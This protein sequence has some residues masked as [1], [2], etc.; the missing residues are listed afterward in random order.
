MASTLPVSVAPILLVDL[1]PRIL[2]SIL[3]HAGG[4]VCRT[5]AGLRRGFE[6]TRIAGRSSLSTAKVSDC[7]PY[8]RSVV[9]VL[10]VEGL[11][12]HRVRHMGKRG[13]EFSSKLLRATSCCFVLLHAPTSKHLTSKLLRPTVNNIELATSSTAL[14]NRAGRAWELECAI[15]HILCFLWHTFGVHH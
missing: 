8:A 13:F 15:L 5:G 9:R 3:P 14:R 2:G 1:L 4:G 6:S 10:I 7:T 12:G 11:T